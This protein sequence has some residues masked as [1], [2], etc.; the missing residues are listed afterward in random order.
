MASNRHDLFQAIPPRGEDVLGRP[1]GDEDGVEVEQQCRCDVGIG[2]EERIL[3][4]VRLVVSC[5]RREA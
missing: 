4:D 2:E 1:V 3:V 5:V